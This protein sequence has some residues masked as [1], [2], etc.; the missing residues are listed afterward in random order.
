MSAPEIRVAI[1]GASGYI[2]R[3]LVSR[4]QQSDRV[5]AILA[6]DIAPPRIRLLPKTRFAR[7]DVATP[8]P[9]ILADHRIDAVIHLAY[10]LNPA[11]RR[12]RA[13]Q[14]NVAGTDNVLEACRQAGVRHVIY[15]SSASVYGAR[16]D[17]PEFLTETDPVRPVEGFQYS[18]DKIEAESRFAGFAARNPEAAITV[19]RVC[20]VV[21]PSADNFIASAF[22]KPILPVIGSSDPPMQFLHEDDLTLALERCLE[23]RPSGIYNVAGEGVIAW[24]EMIAMMGC[25]ALRLPTPAWRFLTD[26]AWRLGL[27]SESPACGLEFIRHRWTVSSKKI[28]AALGVEFRHTSRS[29][30]E[31]YARQRARAGRII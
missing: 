23:Y 21:G 24:S 27:Q 12:T 18:A 25:P 17:N 16:A 14:V 15:L 13:R 11:R 10:I 3:R 30:W 22:R 26:A 19:L 31:S 2:G 1:T 29:A 5:S 28:Q 8:C 6:T 7:W 9:S 4:L 20:P